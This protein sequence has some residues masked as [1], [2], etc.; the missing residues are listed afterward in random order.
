MVSPSVETVALKENI[1]LASR[2]EIEETSQLLDAAKDLES[3]VN[4]SYLQGEL[5]RILHELFRGAK[6][7]KRI[8]HYMLY[9]RLPEVRRTTRRS[10]LCYSRPLWLNESRTPY[11]LAVALNSPDAGC[12]AKYKVVHNAS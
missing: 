1:L 3:H 11:I 12:I 2:G 4:P 6:Y 5:T 9:C 10:R 8:G 7:W